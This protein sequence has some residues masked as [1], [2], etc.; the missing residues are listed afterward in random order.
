VESPASASG[1]SHSLGK[2]A[3]GAGE[4]QDRE[5]RLARRGV[6]PIALRQVGDHGLHRERLL[7]KPGQTG[8]E[9]A[10]I[11]VP[12]RLLGERGEGAPG[13]QPLAVL[14]PLQALEQEAACREGEQD[15]QDAAGDGNEVPPVAELEP[16]LGDGVVEEGE[17]E[18]AEQHGDAGRDDL[19]GDVLE[20]PEAELEERG[21]D[22]ERHQGQ[23]EQRDPGQHLE[24]CAGPLRDQRQQQVGRE[25]GRGAER[26]PLDLASAGWIVTGDQ[27]GAETE[28][29]GGEDAEDDEQDGRAVE[30]L[31]QEHPSPH[32][33]QQA[34]RQAGPRQGHQHRR[35]ERQ[36]E[37]SRRAW[38]ASGR[39]RRS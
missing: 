29:G 22:P 17:G 26:D 3:P 30:G 39:S 35:H 19:A 21:R 7:D 6:Q 14:Q 27:V 28:D 1:R 24:L 36:A 34:G 15:E 32:R 16:D 25:A 2:R 8:E 12:G 5:V 37:P 23:R 4:G 33:R 9:L 18:P 20:V 11:A 13:R 31:R 38:S 10:G